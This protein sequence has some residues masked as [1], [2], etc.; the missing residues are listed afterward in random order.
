MFQNVSDFVVRKIAEKGLAISRFK[1]GQYFGFIGN[2]QFLKLF[3]SL[4]RIASL[5]Q[6]LDRLLDLVKLFGVGRSRIQGA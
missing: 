1:I 2:S 5:N 6:L 4:L 3:K